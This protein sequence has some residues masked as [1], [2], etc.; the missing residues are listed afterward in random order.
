[1][2]TSEE[3]KHHVVQLDGH[4]SLLPLRFPHTFEKYLHTSPLE[5]PSRIASATIAVATTTTFTKENFSSAPS[6]QLISCLGAGCDKFDLHAAKESGVTVTNTPAQN[7]STVAE[8]AISLYFAVK[9]RIVELN[10]VAK[11]GEMWKGQGMCM[12]VFKGVMPRVCEEE[13]AGI[14]GYGALG[15][16]LHHPSLPSFFCSTSRDDS[17]VA[18]RAGKKRV[19]SDI[20]ADMSQANA[21]KRC[22]R[23]LT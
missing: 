3:F 6:L 18:K 15:K 20:Y 8:H 5:L 4:V 23:L 9:R 7:T 10:E 21:L 14:I 13:V 19:W 16:C 17:I 22:A 12:S 11:Q 2:S 1:M